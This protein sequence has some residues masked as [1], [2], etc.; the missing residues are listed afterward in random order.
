[1]NR[2]RRERAEGLEAL[3]PRLALSLGANA[4][5]I[6]SPDGFAN[7]AITETVSISNPDM[8]T[9]QYELWARYETGQRDQ[10]IRAGTIAPGGW[11]DVS[12]SDPAN[13]SAIAV[14]PDTPYALVLKSDGQLTAALRH[15]DFGSS[16]GESFIAFPSSEWSIASVTRDSATSRDF[17]VVYNPND[18]AVQIQV[19]FWDASQLAFSLTGRIEA[20]RR[21]GWNINRLA[22]LPQGNYSVR[23]Q[24]SDNVIVGHSHYNLVEFISSINIATFDRGALAGTILSA[25]FDDRDRPGCGPNEDTLVAVFNPGAEEAAV[26]LNYIVRDGSGFTHDPTELTIPARGRQWVSMKQ[27]GFTDHDVSIVWESDNRVSVA[28]FSRRASAFIVTPSNRVAAT[29]W[30]FAS[31]FVDRVN[32]SVMNTEDVLA[33]NPTDQDVQVTFTFTF[34]NGSTSVQTRTIGAFGVAD[35]DTDM[36]VQHIGA[37]HPFSVRVEATGPIVA[38]LEHWNHRRISGHFSPTGVP[39]GTTSVLSDILIIPQP[40]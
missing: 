14:R 21:G 15:D 6:Y 4:Q 8:L 12:I 22:S 18:A 36:P 11:D 31:A 2:F 32:A 28:S 40:V 33:F 35:V 9:V 20:L 19:E 25:E 5:E 34:R 23:I 26:T 38:A 39:G 37:G 1:M 16:A 3:E 10:L 17:V 24:S 29:E 7:G 13:P 30:H 27:L